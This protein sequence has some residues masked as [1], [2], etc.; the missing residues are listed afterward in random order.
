VSADAAPLAGFWLPSFL[1]SEAFLPLSN[2]LK[3]L[4]IDYHRR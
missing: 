1:P 4:K 3:T 2:Y